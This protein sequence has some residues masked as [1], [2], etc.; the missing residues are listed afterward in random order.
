MKKEETNIE[1]DIRKKTGLEPVLTPSL[2]RNARNGDAVIVK[3][4]G[5]EFISHVLSISDV[6]DADGVERAIIVAGADDKPLEVDESCVSSVYADIVGKIKS[7]TVLRIGMDLVCNSHISR[8]AVSYEVGSGKPTGD[9]ADILYAEA[10]KLLGYVFPDK[11]PAFTG[12][13]SIH[14]TLPE[15]GNVLAWRNCCVTPAKVV[16]IVG[17]LKRRLASLE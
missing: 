3:A 10:S 8:V 6:G 13:V 12:S 9:I 5:S 15:Y 16:S 11:L 2:G 7:G 14:V 1:K 4:D 17:S